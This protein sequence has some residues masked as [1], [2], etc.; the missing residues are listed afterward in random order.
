MT[1]VVSLSVSGDVS[2]D[3]RKFLVHSIA[4]KNIHRSDNII[5]LCVCKQKGT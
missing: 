1:D 4:P 5:I 2:V 3:E